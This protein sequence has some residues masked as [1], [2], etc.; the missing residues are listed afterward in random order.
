MSS[1][2]GTGCAR[3]KYRL[4]ADAQAYEMVNEKSNDPRWA[5]TNWNVYS[6]PRSRYYDPYNPDRPPMPAD[7]PAS[8]EFMVGVAGLK[9]STHWNDDGTRDTLDNPCWRQQLVQYAKFNDRDE[10]V[11]DVNSAL[12]LSLVHSPDYQRQLETIYLSALDVT[13]E[14]FRF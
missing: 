14:R 1:T 10:V 9:G 3:S 12:Q 2:L 13:T 11:L 7:D 8:H 5:L 4:A 6:D